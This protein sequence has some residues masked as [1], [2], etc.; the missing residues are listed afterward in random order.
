MSSLQVLQRKSVDN[1]VKL[2][3]ISVT[4]TWWRAS[5]VEL[6]KLSPFQFAKSSHSLTTPGQCWCSKYCLN[7]R[8]SQWKCWPI[9]W[10]TTILVIV[11]WSFWK[12]YLRF[13]L[14]QVKLYLISSFAKNCWRVTS[15][16]GERVCSPKSRPLCPHNQKKKAH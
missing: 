10:L 12:L 3:N 2:S 8:R 11:F 6:Q 15:R 16:G 13:H 7:Y 1:V 5:F 14:P 4:S 9:Y